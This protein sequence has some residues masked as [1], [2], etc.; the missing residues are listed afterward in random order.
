MCA[1]SNH[2]ELY[3]PDISAKIKS[4][5]SCCFRLSLL[6]EPSCRLDFEATFHLDRNVPAD[7][8]VTSLTGVGESAQNRGVAF[9]TT[10]WTV[11]LAAQG[12]SPAA[13]EALEKLCCT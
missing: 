9:A 1:S 13:Q 5:D 8:Q 11:V 7:H 4:A 3:L 6:C 2:T 10:H 12:E